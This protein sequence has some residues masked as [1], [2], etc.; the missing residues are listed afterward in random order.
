M[1]AVLPSMR[2]RVPLR[3]LA[4]GKTT[5]VYS[6]SFDSGKPVSKEEEYIEVEDFSSHKKTLEARYPKLAVS[7]LNRVPAEHLLKLANAM[8]CLSPD[9]TKQLNLECRRRLQ[10]LPGLGTLSAAHASPR[11]V[12]KAAQTLENEKLVPGK[13]RGLSARRGR[14]PKPSRFFLGL[15]GMRTLPIKMEVFGPG[16]MIP[17]LSRLMQFFGAKARYGMDEKD[18]SQKD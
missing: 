7:Q 14:F 11:V 13:Y 5:S 1:Q 17:G 8:L 6:T 18:S 15:D 4:P 10:L 2:S 16:I 12:A 3:I 9:E